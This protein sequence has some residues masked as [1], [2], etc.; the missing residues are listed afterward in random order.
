MALLFH[1]IFIKL[2]SS[3][4]LVDKI[5]DLALFVSYPFVYFIILY[6]DYLFTGKLRWQSIFCYF[7]AGNFIV[8]FHEIQL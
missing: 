7:T 6:G 4:N 1:L 8:F 5:N 3:E 2:L